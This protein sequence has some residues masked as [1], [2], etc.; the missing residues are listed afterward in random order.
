MKVVKSGIVKWEPTGQR[1]CVIC[2]AVL[3]VERSDLR[4]DTYRDSDQRGDS[5]EAKKYGFSCPEC[6]HFNVM[7]DIPTVVQKFIPRLGSIVDGG[8]GSPL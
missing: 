7:K 4:Y 8:G 1:T 2:E 5:W 6:G 3:E